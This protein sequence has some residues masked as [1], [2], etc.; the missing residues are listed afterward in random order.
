MLL[1]RLNETHEVCS[2]V[3]AG[4]VP[5]KLEI[6]NPCIY[7]AAQFMTSL[8]GVASAK[9]PHFASVQLTIFVT[10]ITS[11]QVIVHTPEY[12]FHPLRLSGPGPGTVLRS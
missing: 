4:C 6:T 2:L 12:G 3:K 5:A 10:M 1:R 7:S 9:Q 8:I 11:L